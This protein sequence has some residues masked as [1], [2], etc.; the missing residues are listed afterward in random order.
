MKWR[1]ETLYA[2]TP[3]L[4]SDPSMKIAHR[5]YALEDPVNDGIPAAR[6]RFGYFDCADEKA[7][8]WSFTCMAPKTD[9]S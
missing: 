9:E 1:I 4:L 7:Q 2:L 5:E 3:T 8:M 6:L